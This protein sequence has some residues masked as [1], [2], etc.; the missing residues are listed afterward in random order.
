MPI[1]S[2]RKLAINRTVPFYSVT[3]QHKD[4]TTD[5]YRA[6]AQMHITCFIR[7]VGHNLTNSA[8]KIGGCSWQ[9]W[10]QYPQYKVRS[11]CNGRSHLTWSTRCLLLLRISS[12][13]LARY[14]RD[15]LARFKTMRIKQNLASALH[16]QK[17]KL[18]VTMHFLE[19]IKLSWKERHI[20][21]CIL[22]PFTN[23]VD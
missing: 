5:Y 19:I 3:D 12:A 22:K 20:L 13:H 7:P 2:L 6:L 23:V 11:V 21:L 9:Q 16:I 8:T 18:G 14:Y 17:R 15:I 10:N 1:S 4:R